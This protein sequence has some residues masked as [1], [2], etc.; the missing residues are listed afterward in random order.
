MQCSV[1]CVSGVS[2]L[3]SGV[4]GGRGIDSYYGE[5]K[6]V[7]RNFLECG[8]RV[9]GGGFLSHA[10][11]EE[12]AVDWRGDCPYL[13][14]WPSYLRHLTRSTKVATIPTGLAGKLYG[15]DVS[16]L[17]DIGTRI[18]HGEGRARK[19]RFRMAGG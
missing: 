2:R 14:T 15:M 12:Q 17:E 10:G 1:V 3:G 9:R 8:M 7:H 4:G 19:G 6:V 13:P 11:D 5:V 16:A 18:I